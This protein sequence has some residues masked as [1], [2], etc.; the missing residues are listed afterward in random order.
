MYGPLNL[1]VAGLGALYFPECVR[2]YCKFTTFH[3]EKYLEVKAKCNGDFIKWL[4]NE[5]V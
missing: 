4:R 2:G 5:D 1:N 3:L